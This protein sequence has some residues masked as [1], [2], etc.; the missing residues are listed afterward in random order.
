MAG[1]FVFFVYRTYFWTAFISLIF[2]MATRDYYLKLKNKLYDKI[3]F[4]APWIMVVLVT[5]TIFFPLY[6]IVRS[7][8]QDALSL[9]LIARMS[10]TEEKLMQM[11][12]S[13]GWLTDIITQ[14][15]FFWVKI[16]GLYSEIVGSYGDILNIDNVYGIISNATSIILGGI[17]LPIGIVVNLFFSYMLLFFLYKDGHKLEG[18]LL[19]AIPIPIEIEKGIGR[20]IAYAIKTVV[21]GNIIISTLQG[22][23]MGILLF[24]VG[25]PNP[26]FYGCIAAIFSLIP[27]IGTMVV[28]LPVGLYLGLM[29]HEWIVS[30]IFMSVAFSAYLFLENL[31]KP[32]ILDKKLKIH[33]LL[34]F[35]ALIGGLK[36]FG[37]MGVIIGPV[38][39]TI[40]VI[41]WDVAITYYKDIRNLQTDREV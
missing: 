38:A 41:L 16:P 7:L 3:K 23:V 32:N 2:Y 19:E 35:L 34:L 13:L 4:V 14:S 1:I 22:S 5:F 20:R 25:I 9:L 6:F 29:D 33:P 18:F 8:L 24:I 12:L 28:W 36:E 39:V 10:L 27:I 15:E 17:K 30:I 40:L 11:I 37:I 21:K 31:L 26:I